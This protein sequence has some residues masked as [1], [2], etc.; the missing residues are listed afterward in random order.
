MIW[1][2]LGGAGLA[3]LVGSTAFGQGLSAEQR[4]WVAKGKRFERAG[5]IYL[6]VAGEARERGVQHGYLLAKEIGAGVQVTKAVWEHDSAMDW[7][8]LVQR[9]AAMFVPKMD[10]ENLA[11][12]DGIA[13]GA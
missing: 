5:W 3:V 2:L 6:H 9:E 7:H 12:L 11:E 1:K 10:S 13:E 4:A 8:W